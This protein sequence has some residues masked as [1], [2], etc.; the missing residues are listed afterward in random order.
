MRDD[1]RYYLR[2]AGAD[3]E[4]VPAFTA[5][6]TALR[7]AAAEVAQERKAVAGKVNGKRWQLST[8]R[9]NGGELEYVK[10]SIFAVDESGNLL[11]EVFGEYGRAM[12]N[13]YN[14]ARENMVAGDVSLAVQD[15]FRRSAH[16]CE[17]IPLRDRG[18]V[19]FVPDSAR[20]MI[21]KARTFVEGVRGSFSSY[22]VEWQPGD[23][24]ER[25]IV[26]SVSGHLYGLVDAFRESMMAAAQA[27]NP[28]AALERRVEHAQA[29]RGQIG[30]Y[31]AMLGAIAAD[32]SRKVQEAEREAAAAAAA[33]IA[34]REAVA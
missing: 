33:S 24:T 5:P 7:R 34:Q 10:D 27:K 8:C 32:L 2:R 13:A 1:A 28:T 3:P 17:L 12:Q 20:E 16:W 25:A 15:I 22:A 21:E 29:L 14:K 18:G 19:Y 23:Y 31:S 30:A 26:E 4:I 6:E 9:N 11:S